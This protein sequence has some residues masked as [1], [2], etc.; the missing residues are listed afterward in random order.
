MFTAFLPL[1]LIALAFFFWCG[2]QMLQLA[3]ESR[4]L[5][6]AIKN[7]E[8]TFQN[9]TKL[10]QSLDAIAG[11][12]KKLAD[13]GNPNAQLLVDDLKRRGITINASAA[14]APAP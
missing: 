10:R 12:T 8:Q 2:F 9:A 7:Q 14:N 1:L 11:Q 13:E 6:A 5:N 3:S 4:A